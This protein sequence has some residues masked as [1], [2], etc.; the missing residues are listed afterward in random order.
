MPAVA[1]RCCQWLCLAEREGRLLYL[2]SGGRRAAYALGSLTEGLDRVARSRFLEAR[3]V[4]GQEPCRSCWARYLCGGGCHV[5]VIAAGRTGCDYI[6]GWLDYCLSV[7]DELLNESPDLFPPRR[8]Q[9]SPMTD[10]IFPRNLTARAERRTAGNP[11]NTRLESGVANCFPGLEFDHRNLDRRFFPGLVFDFNS[12]AGPADLLRTG[13]RLV[14][15][16]TADPDLNP[17]DDATADRRAAARPLRRCTERRQGGTTL[18]SGNWFL[19]SITQGGRK[20]PLSVQPDGTAGPQDGLIV[21][22]LVHVLEPGQE[23]EVTLVQ[24]PAT[25]VSHRP[26]RRGS[27]RAPPPD[28]RQSSSRDGGATSRTRSPVCSRWP[29]VRVS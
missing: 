27:K 6:R 18:G 8:Q 14:Q 10:K 1:L 7:Y 9:G 12:N 26:R 25:D 5:E 2:P 19:D 20:I 13:A 4:D 29:T 11:D 28:R 22:R 15:V 17:G 3:H 16:D 21:W 23:V 24:R